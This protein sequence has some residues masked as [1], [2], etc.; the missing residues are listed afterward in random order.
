[1][2]EV[3]P[4]N[5]PTISLSDT[6]YPVVIWKDRPEITRIAIFDHKKKRI[7]LK[8]ANELY[9]QII[10]ESND[11]TFEAGDEFSIGKLYKGIAV[12]NHRHNLKTLKTAGHICHRL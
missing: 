11:F 8:Q 7:S 2:V 4:R 1:M 9:S 3:V 6:I 5:F 12:F 10:Y